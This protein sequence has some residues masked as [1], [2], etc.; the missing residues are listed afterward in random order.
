M[1][2]RLGEKSS[3]GWRVFLLVFAVCLIMQQTII[4]LL[5]GLNEPAIAGC[6]KLLHQDC[7]ALAQIQKREVKSCEF[8]Q[9]NAESKVEMF[10]ISF[11]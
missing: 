2:N 10:L 5:T 1:T 4:R 8:L 3:F 6:G 7:L 11:L 9:R